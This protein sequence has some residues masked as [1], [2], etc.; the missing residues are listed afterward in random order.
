MKITNAE[1]LAWCSAE[2][3]HALEMHTVYAGKHY[4][5]LRVEWRKDVIYGCIVPARRAGAPLEV[6]ACWVALPYQH[7]VEVNA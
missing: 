5:L 7:E 6:F 1:T 2:T 3:Q 4:R